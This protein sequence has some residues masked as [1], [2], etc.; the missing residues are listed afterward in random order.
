VLG[1]VA[2]CENTASFEGIVGLFKVPMLRLLWKKRKRDG[3]GS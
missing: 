3:N 1:A 2:G